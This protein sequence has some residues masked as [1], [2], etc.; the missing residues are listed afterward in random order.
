M[1]FSKLAEPQRTAGC[2]GYRISVILQVKCFRQTEYN[3]CFSLG[4]LGNPE[5]RKQ[6]LKVCHRRIS[7]FHT[8]HHQMR[9]RQKLFHLQSQEPDKAAQSHP[10][11]SRHL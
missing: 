6:R 10:G 1:P 3:E 2:G 5:K 11:D 8:F 4:I 7:P 9:Q